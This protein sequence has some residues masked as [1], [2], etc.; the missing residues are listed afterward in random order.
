MGYDK[1]VLDGKLRLI[2]LKSLGAAYVTGDFP[3]DLLVEVLD[4]TER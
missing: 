4:G 2:L 3:R 1:K